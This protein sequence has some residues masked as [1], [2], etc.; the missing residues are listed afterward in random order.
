MPRAPTPSAVA[1]PGKAVTWVRNPSTHSA[2]QSDTCPEKWQIN[3]RR[4]LANRLHR[5]H[6]RYHLPIC[7][8]SS[9]LLS[10]DCKRPRKQMPGNASEVGPARDARPFF[11]APSV[12][13]GVGWME[14]A[15]EKILELP[16]VKNLHHNLLNPVQ[17]S[18]SQ[19][20]LRR[21]SSSSFARARSSSLALRGCE[22][23]CV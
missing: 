14:A 12:D 21:G 2:K 4:F 20:P 1:Q 23:H 13:G 18:N 5:L 16:F 9:A 3:L 11:S 17:S 7:F 10:L 19:P 15:W 8:C 22:A 6:E